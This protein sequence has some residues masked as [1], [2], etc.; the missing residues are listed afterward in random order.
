MTLLDGI[1]ACPRCRGSG[2][3]PALTTPLRTDRIASDEDLAKMAR[4]AKES[5]AIFDAS[6]GEGILAI[7]NRL[8][9]AEASKQIAS[10][11]CKAKAPMP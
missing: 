10:A 1:T 8:R 2:S 7:L 9:A 3:D 4:F 11:Y 5:A 6:F